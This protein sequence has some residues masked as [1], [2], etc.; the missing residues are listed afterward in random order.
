MVPPVAMTPMTVAPITAM[1]TAMTD[2]TATAIAIAPPAAIAHIL[3]GAD[4]ICLQREKPGRKL[5]G[6]CTRSK[7]P[8]CERHRAT[9]RDKRKQF[10]HTKYPF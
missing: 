8:K 10:F 7:A 3:N 2:V 5:R 9:E 4:P 1:P 6:A